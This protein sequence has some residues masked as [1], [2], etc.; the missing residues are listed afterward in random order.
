MRL[1]I[2]EGGVSS[3]APEVGRGEAS[4]LRRFFCGL[5]QNYFIQKVANSGYLC[6]FVEN[7]R[8]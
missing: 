6:I 1:F 7:F 3:S 5:S 2:A 4:A 8:V